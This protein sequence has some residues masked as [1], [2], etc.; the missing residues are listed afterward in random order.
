MSSIIKPGPLH[1]VDI[2]TEV[3]KP[4]DGSRYE[5]GNALVRDAGQKLA[6]D[7]YVYLGSASEPPPE[8]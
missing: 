3:V 7:G 1:D 4:R 5:K 2:E 8:L 6:P